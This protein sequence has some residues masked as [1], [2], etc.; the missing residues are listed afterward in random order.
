MNGFVFQ[1]F[2]DVLKTIGIFLF[3]F[4]FAERLKQNKQSD[5]GF[6]VI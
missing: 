1:F 2:Q 6:G 4:F 5:E 3:F